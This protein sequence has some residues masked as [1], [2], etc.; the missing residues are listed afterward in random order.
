VLRAFRNND[1]DGNGKKDTYGFT[2]AG[3]GTSPSLEWPEWIKNGLTYALFVENNKFIDMQSDLRFEK[4][5]DDIVQLIK[6]DLVD[7]D[8]FLNKGPQVEDK[9]IQGKVGV[10]LG[11]SKNFAYDSNPQSIQVRSKAINPKAE[12]QPFVPFV[13]TPLATSN[14]PGSPFLI[15]KTTA[16]KSPEKVARIIEILDWLSSQEGF[17]LTHYGL[18]GKHYKKDGNNISLL[19]DAITNDIIKQGDFLKIWDFFTPN[20]PETFGLT[21]VDPNETDR[22]RGINKFL[23][24]IPVRDNIGTNVTP[25]TGFDLAAF[26]SK[27]REYQ[28]KLIMDEKS[29]KNYPKYY[30]ELMTVYGGEKMFKAYEEQMKAVGMIK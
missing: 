26:R 29:G 22:D 20:T 5:A 10:V 3:N 19:Q 7:P 8:W 30:Q 24:S 13:D 9:A 4:V 16:E 28:V 12:W 23:L 27:M 17:L 18:E 6:E 11:N 2:T 14:L 25:P 21:V 15:P 1:P